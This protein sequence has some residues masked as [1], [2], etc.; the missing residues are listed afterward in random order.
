[1]RIVDAK[2]QPL[3][4]KHPGIHIVLTPGTVMAALVL[5]GKD[6]KEL[7]GDWIMLEAVHR[8]HY[9]DLKTD[10][11]GRVTIPTLVPGAPYQLTSTEA[12]YD[13]IK[14]LRKTKFRVRPGETV[15]LPDFVL[16]K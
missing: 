13:R 7:E 15:T 2:G 8:G 11:D 10:A 5:S 4:G 16:G 3:A 6:D 1:V 9:L 12:E 14:G